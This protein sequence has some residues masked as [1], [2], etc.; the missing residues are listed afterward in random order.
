M[1]GR[2]KKWWG[3]Q[4]GQETRTVATGAPMP[5]SGRVFRGLAVKG[6]GAAEASRWQRV[7]ST[8]C[9]PPARPV[10]RASP[11]VPPSSP[12]GT[13]PQI[14]KLRH[15]EVKSKVAE[16]RSGNGHGLLVP[17]LQRPWEIGK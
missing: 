3:Q 10:T 8:G 1:P 15:D 13:V 11:L 6:A 14:G 9:W 7:P 16:A 5:G 4:Q 2:D 12:R 17:L